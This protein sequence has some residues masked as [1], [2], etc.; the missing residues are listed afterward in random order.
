MGFP[1]SQETGSAMTSLTLPMGKQ[2][3]NMSSTFSFLEFR[4]SKV[5]F[6]WSIL[7]MKA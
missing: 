2:G 3:G 1:V 6:T 5:A 4:G 7:F